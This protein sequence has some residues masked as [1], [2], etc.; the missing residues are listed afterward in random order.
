MPDPPLA[1]QL[2]QLVYGQLLARTVCVAAELRLADE[3]VDG[4]ATA[5]TLARRTTTDHIALHRLLRGLVAFGVL[6]D[7]GDG[8]FALTDLGQ[9]L[10]SDRPDSA[11]PTALLAATVTGPAWDRLGSVVRSGKPAFPDAFG[12]DFFGYLEQNPDARAIFDRSQEAGIALELPEILSC[13]DLADAL[14]VDVGGGDGALLAAVLA[15]NPASRGILADL[16][17]MCLFAGGQERSADDYAQLLAVAGFSAVRTTRLST[18]AGV[19]EA[20]P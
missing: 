14:I 11:L 6:A 2:R 17:M 20:E 18:G 16:Y 7:I 15:A 3:L 12:T 19:L 5:E 4:P 10:R 8:R 9:T 13:V 1:A